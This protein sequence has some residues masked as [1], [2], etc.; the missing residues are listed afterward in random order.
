LEWENNKYIYDKTMGCSTK[1]NILAVGGGGTGG[2]CGLYY[3]NGGGGSGYINYTSTEIPYTIK[4][5]LDVGYGGKGHKS[6][7][8]SWNEFDGKETGGGGGGLIIG[9]ISSDSKEKT[10]SVRADTV[11]YGQ[12]GDGK[13]GERS[14]GGVVLIELDINVSN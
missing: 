5:N 1:I 10:K 12:G 13:Y 4:L 6:N 3:H 9:D 2:Q 11:S 8:E 14:K 7:C